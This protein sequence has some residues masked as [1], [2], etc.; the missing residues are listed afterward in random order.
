L[1]GRWSSGIS[2][3]S[4]ISD[5]GAA[6]FRID[7]TLE[8]QINKN[9][10][11]QASY[12]EEGKKKEVISYFDGTLRNR[13]TVTRINSDNHAVVGEVI[14]DAQGRPGVEVLPVPTNTN[15]L[16]FFEDFNKN[17]S[18]GQ[19]ASRSYT[20]KDFDLDTQNIEDE[21]SAVKAMDTESGASKY[22]SSNND[23]NDG[24]RDRVADADEFPF[25]QIEYTPDNTGRIRR[26]SGVGKTHQLGGKHEMEYYYATPE[27]IELNR[28]FGYS[29]GNAK[30]YKKNMVIDPNRQASISYL[31]PQGRTIATALSGYAPA[32]LL[33]LDDE[34]DANNELHKILETDLL[35]K[36]SREDKDTRLDF[37]IS[38]VSGEYG[39]L[40]DRLDFGASKIS[41]FDEKRTF[42]Y[43]LTNTAYVDQECSSSVEYPVVY[44][45]NFNVLD[46]N[47][48]T[49]L[50]EG[51]PTQI[52]SSKDASVDY[53]IED[54]VVSVPRGSYRIVK[55]LRVNKETLDAYADAYVA[56]LTDETSACYIPPSNPV[57]L[58]P[59][60][61]DGCF[62]SCKE[63]EDALFE[64]K[65]EAQAKSDFVN[66]RV[67]NFDFSE[68]SHLSASDLD[69]E[70]DKLRGVFTKQFEDAIR[71][72]N[73][74]CADVGI[75]QDGSDSI[76][77][78]IIQEQ[79]VSDLRPKGQYGDS[80]FRLVEQNAA[81]NDF[82]EE[83]REIGNGKLSIFNE[84]NELF[85]TRT[86]AEKHS[87]WRNPSYPG[88]DPRREKK[89]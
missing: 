3:K 78:E 89:M 71:A 11:F 23:V 84:D 7:A 20:Y 83:N 25:S 13:Q 86:S 59:I 24:F 43:R 6:V 60:T 66:D 85:S 50:S 29:V 52:N 15:E 31:D 19:E 27:Q 44:D 49:L 68:L 67:D 5:W 2:K 79:L 41:P 74:P 54:L 21:F 17:T 51:L 45:F 76:S 36:K 82:V 88:K 8:H 10:Q 58:P 16:N 22:Y 30:H 61:I 18:S 57:F 72:C 42:N 80:S 40:S 9:W 38:G 65:T 48:D 46:K 64:G 87:S 1:Y 35:N 63:C 70:K 14:Y 26:K 12:A 33:G 28:L 62:E 34:I 39:A 73:A 53:K 69:Q 75:T 47:S 81:N 4:K 32:A 77:C 55:N 37:N 56:S